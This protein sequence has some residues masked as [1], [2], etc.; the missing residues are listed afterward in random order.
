MVNVLVDFHILESSLILNVMQD[1]KAP[2]DST[3]YYNIYKAHN[4]SQ[5][6]FD[7]SF[8]YYASKPEEL[9]KIYERVVERINTMQA[10]A[11][12]TAPPDTTRKLPPARKIH[13]FRPPTAPATPK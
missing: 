10:E 3:L 8:K 6:E 9:N 13:G 5:D 2:Q 4:I 12:K 7:A 1:D 11:L